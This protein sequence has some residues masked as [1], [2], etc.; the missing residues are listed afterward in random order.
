MGR[1]NPA[2]VMA[3]GENAPDDYGPGARFLAQVAMLGAG[4]VAGFY[5]ISTLSGVD[6]AN[7]GIV[8]VG[9][10][11]AWTL[12]VVAALKVPFDAEDDRFRH[13]GLVPFAIG[14]SIL[15]GAVVRSMDIEAI[16]TPIILGIASGWFGALALR[17]VYRT[18]RK[19]VRGSLPCRVF[20][21]CSP[22]GR[23]PECR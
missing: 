17:S 19:P 10:F 16:V 14:L 15:G 4:V 3:S 9:S 5:A 6:A 2:D 1:A 7:R 21:S 23:V 8:G 11:V 22:P 13:R 20:G 18:W 12:A